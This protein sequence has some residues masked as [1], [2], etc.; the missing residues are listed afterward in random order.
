MSRRIVVVG[1]GFAGLWGAASA[2][3][4]RA[5]FGVPEDELEIVLV[6][7]DP[8]H[9][10]R[11]R[12]YE[13]DLEPVRV[14]LDDTL[15]P[16][17]VRRVEGRVTSI[18]DGAR[19]VAVET[20]EGRTALDYDRLL[21]APGSALVRP[22]VPLGQ[23]TFDVDTYEGAG[24]LA[25]HLR[26]LAER[27][28]GEAVRTAVVVGGGLV[29]IEIACELPGRLH[30]VLG[31]DAPVR[32]VLVDRGDIGASMGRGKDTILG[33]LATLGVLTRP[34]AGVVAVDAAGVTLTSGEHIPAATVVFATGMRASALTGEL[35]VPCDPLGRVPVD[36]FLKVEGVEAVYA[37]GDCAR[38]EADDLGHASVMS[39]QHARPMGRL[40]GH[41]AAC[42]LTGHMEDRVLFSA[43]DYVT[44]VDLGPCGA[45]YT[46]GWDRDALVATG[47][48]AKATKQTINGMRIY[49]P[50]PASRDAVF[51]A[52]AP[53]IQARPGVR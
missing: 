43:P 20:A 15:K 46:G 8:F 39:C 47:A 24:R 21:L 51:A 32:V 44:V 2:A 16:I 13:A 33:A 6:S 1:G 40:A 11:V 36:G 28:D 30:D 4:A 42:D 26:A 37:A 7:P 27:G 3:R 41:N 10:I 52:A 5:L 53:I 25:A 31:A 50:R 18:D 22:L 45:V 9:T 34:H 49:P 35:G 14:P 19:A 38:V 29:G 17:G 48:E 23:E 12:C